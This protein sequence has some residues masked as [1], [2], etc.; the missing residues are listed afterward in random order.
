MLYNMF[1]KLILTLLI[2]VVIIIIINCYN[3]KENFAHWWC[4]SKN[5]PR[6]YVEEG[7]VGSGPY[8]WKG[9][10]LNNNV[11][12]RQEGRCLTQLIEEGEHQL[13]D[14]KEMAAAGG[15]DRVI[16]RVAYEKRKRTDLLKKPYEWTA[17]C[18]IPCALSGKGLGH[19]DSGNTSTEFE[20][21]RDKCRTC[22]SMEGLKYIVELAIMAAS[23]G[24]A[25]AASAG[26]SAGSAAAAAGAAYLP[27]VPGTLLEGVDLVLDLTMYALAKFDTG[28][29][30]CDWFIGAYVPD[31][32]LAPHKLLDVSKNIAN[33]IEGVDGEGYDDLTIEDGALYFTKLLD[34]VS[35]NW[36]KIYGNC[37]NVGDKRE[38]AQEDPLHSGKIDH[39]FTSAQP[40]KWFGDFPR[41]SGIPSGFCLPKGAK[42][43]Y[44]ASGVASDT[45]KNEKG[46]HDRHSNWLQHW[47][48]GSKVHGYDST[49]EPKANVSDLITYLATNK[50]PID[51]ETRDYAG[52]M[53]WIR[54]KLE[55]ESG[56]KDNKGKKILG[57]S[58]HNPWTG[59]G[60]GAS[61]THYVGEIDPNN[62]TFY[63]EF[64][65]YR[66]TINTTWTETV[67]ASSLGEGGTGVTTVP[68]KKGA[69][70]LKDCNPSFVVEGEGT[71]TKY[72]LPQI[73]AR[74]TNIWKNIND[75]WL[76]TG[77]TGGENN[78]KYFGVVAPIKRLTIN[79]GPYRTW[80]S[81]MKSEGSTEAKQRHNK[82]P[83]RHMILE[84][85]DRPITIG[86]NS[87]NDYKNL[88]SSTGIPREFKLDENGKIIG[89][90]YMLDGSPMLSLKEQQKK[91]SELSKQIRSYLSDILK[92]R[93]NN[94]TFK[95]NINTERIKLEKLI[96]KIKK[97]MRK[98]NK[99][100]IEDKQTKELI[101]KT[102]KK[103]RKNLEK[104]IKELDNK[105]KEQNIYKNRLSNYTGKSSITY[106]DDLL[107]KGISD[108]TK[109][110]ENKVPG[111]APWIYVDDGN[112]KWNTEPKYN[113]DGV[114]IPGTPLTN[115][116][117]DEIDNVIE[118]WGSATDFNDICCVGDYSSSQCGIERKPSKD[119]HT[120]T[121]LS[122]FDCRFNRFKHPIKLI[123]GNHDEHGQSGTVSWTDTFGV[124]C[125]ASKERELNLLTKVSNIIKVMGIFPGLL[126]R[127]FHG[128]SPLPPNWASMTDN[129][130]DQWH[131]SD[132][133]TKMVK[134]LTEGWTN[135]LESGKPKATWEKCSDGDGYEKHPWSAS[136]GKTFKGKKC[137]CGG[138]GTGYVRYGRKANVIENNSLKSVNNPLR[139]A[140]WEIWSKSLGITGGEIMC[141]RKNFDNLILPPDPQGLRTPD[142]RPYDRDFTMECQCLTKDSSWDIQ[143][144]PPTWDD[145]D[146]YCIPSSND[147]AANLM[148]NTDDEKKYNIT[149]GSNYIVMDEN[150]AKT[151]CAEHPE[152]KGF[153]TRINDGKILFK[154]NITSVSSKEH[155]KYRCSRKNEPLPNKDKLTEWDRDELLDDKIW[156]S[157]DPVISYD[158]L[159]NGNAGVYE[160]VCGD[161]PHG[162]TQS[163]KCTGGTSWEFVNKKL[164]L[165][166]NTESFT[167]FKSKDSFMEKFAIFQRALATHVKNKYNKNN[168]YPEQN[169]L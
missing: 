62:K 111:G 3:T 74:D 116:N 118:S 61:N 96:K 43:I 5:R 18:D 28:Q 141:D 87:I 68:C 34:D 132:F 134:L 167:N 94:V 54:K 165:V 35:N 110:F 91:R 143:K 127:K 81:S 26:A 9:F 37:M 12:A 84:L 99:P 129:E 56:T 102:I 163:K 112:I 53:A 83:P 76:M 77:N 64:A 2:I 71:Y 104:N 39:T 49:K 6:E 41:R 70:K 144:D 150:N 166:S 79:I 85:E 142:Y 90:T 97:Q 48:V 161:D 63:I 109:E 117:G 15:D 78:E 88:K 21:C 40:G 164:E 113:D 25:G 146:G 80:L 131:L 75:L 125:A 105:V 66:P 4:P 59:H 121:I 19:R 120:A 10:Y 44:C 106:W 89:F 30:K 126:S 123:C 147:K 156:P 140:E 157:Y 24:S 128:K 95:E 17:Y 38:C 73:D 101:Q 72:K 119:S 52:I 130:H 145:N 13:V 169:K 93:D 151:K 42:D 138:D 160:T 23:G 158:K 162:E 1:D 135:G 55:D 139:P 60:F 82:I 47:D 58:Q 148:L 36:K 33:R 50:I 22:W 92:L 159:P 67:W 86:D 27:G 29:Q 149:G 154:K 14:A 136:S 11:A 108:W 115:E 31:V 153:T 133:N 69:K 16:K 137:K 32:F 114:W 155:T 8:K 20:N 51:G 152:C 65:D 168:S 46:L 122:G 7:L 100:T 98:G 103:L 124:Y 107:D 57:I 45:S